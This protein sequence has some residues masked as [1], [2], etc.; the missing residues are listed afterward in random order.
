[1]T[2]GQ[3][4]I[5]FASAEVV[6]ATVVV[7]D[8]AIDA[9]RPRVQVSAAEAAA[10]EARLAVLRRKAKAGR[11]VWDVAVEPVEAEAVPA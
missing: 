11:A 5:G 4:E 8:Q 3:S 7:L 2:S 1:M 10:H 9:P 6:E